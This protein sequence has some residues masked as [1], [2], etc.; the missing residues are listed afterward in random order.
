MRVLPLHWAVAMPSVLGSAACLNVFVMLSL[1]LGMA[2]KAGAAKKVKKEVQERRE[3][4]K[5]RIVGKTMSQAAQNALIDATA[6]ADLAKVKTTDL[7]NY[8][9]QMSKSWG[10]SMTA[11]QEAAWLTYKSAGRTDAI[12]RA[13]VANW[14]Q[15][16]SCVWVATYMEEKYDQREEVSVKKKGFMTRWQVAKSMDIDSSAVETPW[17]EALLKS[18]PSDT[19]WDTTFQDQRAYAAAGELRYHVDGIDQAGVERVISGAKETAHE[20]TSSTSHQRQ[21][22]DHGQPEIEV[23]NPGYVKLMDI[24]KVL[25]SGLTALRRQAEQVEEALDLL[26]AKCARKDK[27]DPKQESSAWKTLGKMWQNKVEKALQ[28]TAGNP[29]LMVFLRAL[30]QKVS[31]FSLITSTDQVPDELLKD[32]FLQQTTTTT[33]TTKTRGTRTTPRITTRTT[34]RVKPI[35][36]RPDC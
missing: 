7:A 1:A 21:L 24:L 34:T 5:R 22:A 35:A 19:D 2:P 20:A 17:F 27:E 8:V 30:S 4:A 36:T 29:G 25:A 23:L 33:T 26:L 3:D 28:G 6:P 12:K 32:S 31:D 13:I 9:T 18:F 10:S 16:K 14:L 15:K 11:E